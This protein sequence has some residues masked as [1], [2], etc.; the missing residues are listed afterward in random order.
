M[1]KHCFLWPLGLLLLGFITFISPA[2]AQHLAYSGQNE[3][4]MELRLQNGVLLP[5]GN[6]WTFSG[7][8]QMQSIDRYAGI[9]YFIATGDPSGDEILF[10]ADLEAENA[11]EVHN[12]GPFSHTGMAFDADGVLWLV[13]AN[14]ELY[15]YDPIADSLTLESTLPAAETP[16][17]LAWW[18]GSLHVLY[19]SA[20]LEQ[21]PVFATVDVSTGSLNDQREL[22]GLVDMDTQFRAYDSIDFDDAGG[23][24]IGG[25]DSYGLVDPPSAGWMAHFADPWQDSGPASFTIIAPYRFTMPVSV[26]GRSVPISVPAAE[27]LGLAALA[28]LLAT[29]AMFHFKRSSSS[30]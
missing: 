22:P 20:G 4:L 5:D 7:I 27:N 21:G 11:S 6:T 26:S 15:S 9:L 8:G 10:T 19:Q 29:A 28:A 18:D 2:S 24:W 16:R 3:E 17:G 14:G 23:L 13:R 1:T 12:F 25:I 30:C